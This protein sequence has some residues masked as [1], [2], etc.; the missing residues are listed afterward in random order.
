MKKITKSVTGLCVPQNVVHP[1]V[2]LWPS[3]GMAAPVDTKKKQG[4]FV[5]MKKVI[6]LALAMA[7]AL[8]MTST[9][10]PKI[11]QIGRMADF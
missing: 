2:Y 11:C 5:T 1:S 6:S 9:I 8:S 3:P 4:G 10:L 7:M